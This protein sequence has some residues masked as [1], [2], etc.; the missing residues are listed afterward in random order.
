MD[1]DNWY[2]FV[3]IG[4]I[5]IGVFVVALAFRPSGH[6]TQTGQMTSPSSAMSDSSTGSSTGE[7]G[8]ALPTVPPAKNGPSSPAQPPVVQ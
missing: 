3:F 2:V 8:K 4:I 1:R 5:I 7:S 6:M